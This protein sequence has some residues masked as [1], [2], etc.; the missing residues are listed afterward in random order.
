MGDCEPT[1]ERHE[2]RK[3]PAWEGAR[4]VLSV[5]KEGHETSTRR[6]SSVAVGRPLLRGLWKQTLPLSSREAVGV[7]RAS[8]GKTGIEQRILKVSFLRFNF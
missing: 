8:P 7:R 1:L 5:T 4:E 3:W 6:A 2:M